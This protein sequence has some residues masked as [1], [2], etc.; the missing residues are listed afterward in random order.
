MTPSVPEYLGHQIHVI[1]THFMEVSQLSGTYVIQDEHIALI[2]SGPSP[3]VPYILAGLEKLNIKPEAIHYIIVTHI[4]LDH[5]G[6][7]GVL[8][9]HCP[10]AKVV[11]HPRGARHLADPSR[12]IESAKAVYQEK[13]TRLFH[14]IKPVP[15]ERL[16]IKED[17]ETLA[18]GSE[19]TLHF[20]DTPGHARHHFSIYDPVSKGIFAGDS[21]GIRYPKLE[22]LGGQL[23]IPVTTPNQFDPEAM[24]HSME[25]MM[26]L[27]I[28]RIY[29]GHY[30]MVNQVSKVH[31][32]VT[33]WL[34]R[35]VR[36]GEEAYAKN[37][38]VQQL[39]DRLLKLLLDDQKARYG[40]Q[41]PTDSQLFASIAGDAHLNAMGIYDYLS[42]QHQS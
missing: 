24:K 10:Q 35:F 27:G 40:V 38:S 3:S 31:Q 15:E 42:K 12:L 16:L 13:F 29:L 28:E 34:E 1:D 4:H 30:S 33:A 37:L 8:I 41:I 6:G 17:G 25:R 5:A 36:E 7:V 23:Y 20:I 32:Q 26:A 2:E 14:P 11:V 21:F 9:E 39:A 19:R 18:L 22:A